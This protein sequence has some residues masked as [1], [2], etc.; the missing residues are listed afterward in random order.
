MHE[1]NDVLYVVKKEK[2]NFSGNYDLVELIQDY[3]PKHSIGFKILE[4]THPNIQ[5]IRIEWESDF[6]YVIEPT[7]PAILN[8]FSKKWKMDWADSFFP[9][10]SHAGELKDAMLA[11]ASIIKSVFISKVLK[12]KAGR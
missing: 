1:H 7:D 9:K 3:L 2:I 8:F 6:N 10:R 12:K 11:F 4:R 5:T